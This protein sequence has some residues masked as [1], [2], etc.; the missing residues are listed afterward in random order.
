VGSN[1]A[2]FFERQRHVTENAERTVASL[3]LAN[4]CTVIGFGTLSF[5]RIPVLHGI[6]LTVAIGAVLS[7]IF[8]AICIVA[9]PEAA[10][11]PGSERR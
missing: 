7:L 9:Q 1:Y 8:S 2:L 5:S 11:G 6:G 10:A 4:I 3:V